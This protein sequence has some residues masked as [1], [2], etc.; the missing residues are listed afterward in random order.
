MAPL[1]SE[2]SRGKII[3]PHRTDREP[4]F[5]IHPTGKRK[6][7][8]AKKLLSSFDP[9]IADFRSKNNPPRTNSTQSGTNDRI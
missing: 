9:L 3:S 1:V 5:S 7:L 2:R 8:H 6:F 4:P